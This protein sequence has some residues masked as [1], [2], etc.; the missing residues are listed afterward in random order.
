RPAWALLE[1]LAKVPPQLAHYTFRQACGL[2][3][4]PTAPAVV[5]WL[6]RNA[7]EM[8]PVV[9]PDPKD[10]RTLTLDL[11][12]GSAEL[13]NFPDFADT[14]TFT[15]TLFDA[16]R[17]VGASVGIGKYD[18]ARPIYTSD[19]YRVESSDG[20]E[21]RTLHIGLDLFMKPGTPVFAPL[22]GVVQ[23]FQNNA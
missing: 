20:P 7:D 19:V 18:E 1:H 6:R 13:G 2:P 15:R 14:P 11:S 16:M 4:V 9:A 21:W 12:I 10:T 17:A 5:E 8:A 3:A 23:S 22:D